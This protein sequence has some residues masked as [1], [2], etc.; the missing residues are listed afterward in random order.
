MNLY[1]LTNKLR[2]WYVLSTSPTH[3]QEKLVALLNKAD[4][5]FKSDRKVTNIQLLA[6]SLGEFPEGKPNFSS[7]NTLIL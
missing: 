7:G 4:Y 2:D 3:A 1:L 5:G 6:E